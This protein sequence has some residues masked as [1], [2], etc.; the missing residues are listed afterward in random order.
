M[1]KIKVL[2][3][4]TR[5]NI[6]GPAIQA[7]LL[8]AGL[9]KEMFSSAL[10]TGQVSS[11]EGDM[12]YLA[13]E[14]GVEPLV[15]SELRRE[16]NI[17]N[18]LISF[19]KLYRFVK[20]EKP[21]VVHTH[22]AKA[23]TIGRLAARLTGVPLV[24][25]TFHGHIFHSYFNSSKT[26]FF[27]LIERLLARVTD[28]I[29]VISEEQKDEIK[30]FL[31]LK[32]DNKL[33]LIP[34]GFELNEFLKDDNGNNV[35]KL[36]EELNIPKEAAV[37]GIIGRLTAIKNHKMFL[38][39]AKEVKRKDS[40]K[41][42]KFLIIGDGE[43]KDELIALSSKS[44]IR[45]DVIFA[46]WRKDMDL[47]YKAM[48]IVTLTSLNEGTPVSLI[49]ALASGRTVVATDVGGVRD[50]VENGKSGFIVP[51]NDIDAFSEATSRLLNDVKKRKEFGLYGRDFIKGKYSKDKL[52]DTIENF[53]CRELH[54]KLLQLNQQRK[55]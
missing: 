26:R 41:K 11:G 16:V 24:I 35:D 43:M 45:E 12:S 33:T 52:V 40:P 36:R 19:Y 7:A 42:I 20:K 15:I 23:G 51:S 49:E 48:D 31:K 53:Y 13:K 47:V 8:S 55:E 46:G 29:I 6:G 39:V 17:I 9:D 1:E 5:M 27:L 10:I 34:L 22:M 3:I 32:S 28:K 18:D 21:D 30:R 37:I 14:S 25:H 44:G 2:R 38:E 54:Q 50:I 4:I